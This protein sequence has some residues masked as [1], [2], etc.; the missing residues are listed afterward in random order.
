MMNT[1]LLWIYEQHKTIKLYKLI[2]NKNEFE[3]H[4]DVLAL[5]S[6]FFKRFL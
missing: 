2:I 5:R 1:N 4:L 6:G 3:V